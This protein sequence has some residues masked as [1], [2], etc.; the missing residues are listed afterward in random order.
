MKHLAIMLITLIS[1]SA[2]AR[3]RH[4]IRCDSRVSPLVYVG[5]GRLTIINFPFRP[6]NLAIGERIFDFKQIHDD[7]IIRPLRSFGRTNIVVYLGERRCVFD[8]EIV[9]SRGNGV[10]V[11][12]DQRDS[13]YEVKTDD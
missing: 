7:L 5:V 4:V 11:V 3:P 9:N 10:L 12:K 8:L 13:Q 2:E 6:K 1:L